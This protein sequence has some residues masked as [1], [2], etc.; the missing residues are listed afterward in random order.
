M[1][2]RF[3]VF[4]IEKMVGFIKLYFP[5]FLLGTFFGKLVEMS[6][7]VATIAKTIVQFV[8]AK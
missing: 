5:V 8:G 3:Q 7:L 6:G 4:S 2:C 1:F